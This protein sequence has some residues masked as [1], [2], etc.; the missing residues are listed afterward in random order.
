MTYPKHTNPTLTRSTKGAV[1]KSYPRR[2]KFY[3]IWARAPYNFVPLPDK[4]VTAESPIPSHDS[5]TGYTGNIDC[6]LETQSP[7]YIRGMMSPGEY[8]KYGDKRFDELDDSPQNNQKAQRSRFYTTTSSSPR[9]PGSSLRGMIRAVVEIVTYSKVQWV[10]DEP[11]VYRA[12]ADDAE[13]PLGRTY[14]SQ[15]QTDQ[16]G[17][18]Y[19]IKDGQDWKIRPAR[20]LQG[21]TFATTRT[22]H[23]LG[24]SWQEL[25]NAWEVRVGNGRVVSFASTSDWRIDDLNEQHGEAAVYVQVNRAPNARDGEKN[26]YLFGLPDDSHPGYEIPDDVVDRFKE[27]VS[28]EQSQFLHNDTGALRENQPVFY[29]LDGENRILFFGAARYFRLPYAQSPLGLVPEALHRAPDIDLTDAI[30]GYVEKGVSRETALASRISIHDASIVPGQSNIWMPYDKVMGNEWFTPAILASPK[31]TTFQHYL[32]QNLTCG[33]DPDYRQTLAHYG[34]SKDET[35]I[36]GSKRYW[37]KESTLSAEQLQFNG[38]FDKAKR[39]LTGIRP[40]NQG[41]RFTFRISFVN[42][43]AVELGALLWAL[44]LPSGH[45]HS[46]GMGKPLGMGAVLLKDVRLSLSDRKTR[47]MT[48]FNEHGWAQPLH[49]TTSDFKKRFED[50]MQEQLGAKDTPFGSQERIQALLHLLRFPG[51]SDVWTRYMEIELK[52]G[53]FRVNEYKQR[54]VLP[55]PFHIIAD[56][57]C[58]GHRK[59]ES[60]PKTNSDN[61]LAQETSSVTAS[62]I[63]AA[64]PPISTEPIPD[65]NAEKTT[66]PTEVKKG[67]ST[68]HGLKAHLVGDS[69]TAVVKHLDSQGAWLQENGRDPTDEQI[70]MLSKQLKPG[71]ALP[72]IS[73]SVRCEVLEVKHSDQ[74]VLRYIVTRVEPKRKKK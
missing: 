40:V 41:I 6:V 36:R 11:L 35:S 12:V 26:H 57:E 21:H 28:Q 51:P 42:L 16:M 33:H 66:E 61:K 49:A 7:L 55:D 50:Y 10:T 14:R 3:D 18:G 4:V 73:N 31:P 8:S 30:F 37:H 1:P 29:L 25:P 71:Q 69:F 68:R 2:E 56:K 9:I 23:P 60:T 72:H 27:Q 46:L 39:Q 17:A 20:L 44:E 47:Y 70:V 54:P 5:F 62:R 67:L 24:K 32:T 43:S 19:V 63:S 48:L 22:S 34:T 64:P 59:T 52:D 58:K 53:D 15:L 13:S 65:H 74:G 45:C 38:G